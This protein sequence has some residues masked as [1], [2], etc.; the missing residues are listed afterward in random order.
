MWLQLDIRASG[1]AGPTVVAYSS[2]RGA[3]M[4]MVVLWGL[5]VLLQLQTLVSGHAL[6]QRASS[7]S[8]LNQLQV[9]INTYT[10]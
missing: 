5:L 1:G 6:G 7:T 3:D 9:R 10:S 2:K 8:E 4:R